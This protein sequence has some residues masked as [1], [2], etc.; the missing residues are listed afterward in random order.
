[1]FLGHI[2]GC[3]TNKLDKNNTKACSLSLYK[4]MST[5]ENYFM[6]RENKKGN[7]FSKTEKK[8]SIKLSHFDI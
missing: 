7:S 3:V 8:I 4:T 2:V 1:M 5:Q 6:K